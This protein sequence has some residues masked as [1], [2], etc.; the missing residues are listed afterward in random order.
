MLLSVGRL[1]RASS[2]Q[3]EKDVDESRDADLRGQWSECENVR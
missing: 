1:K 2:A 3:A